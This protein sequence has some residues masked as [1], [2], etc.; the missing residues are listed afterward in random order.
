M[1]YD[2]LLLHAPAIYDFRERILF[3]GPI[4]ETVSGSSSQF[5]IFP[6][7]LLSLAEYVERKGYRVKIINLGELM[8]SDPSF[9]VEHFI[10]KT[11]AD[12]YGVDLH[13][14]VHSQGAMEIARIC[15]SHHP[16]ATVIF[17]GLTSTCFHTE[18]VEKYPFVDAVV[19]G[20]AEESVLQL[21]EENRKL[22][23]VPNVTYRDDNNKVCINPQIKPAA[24][25]DEFEFTRLDLVE[26]VDMLTWV[27]P[28]MRWWNLPICR[29]CTLDC[30]ACGGSKYSYD[31]LFSRR[32]P[33][34]RSPQRIAEDLI[35][36]SEQGVNAVFLFQDP[37]LGGSRYSEDLIATLHREKVDTAIYL[38][39]FYPASEDYLKSLSRLERPVALSISPE[40]AVEEI[41]ATHGRSYSNEAL[42][43]TMAT[44]QKYDLRLVIFFMLG[45]ANETYDTVKE[46]LDFCEK[47]YRMD[48]GPRYELSD[49]GM[50]T[51]HWLIPRIGPM[52]LLDP[53]SYGFSHPRE[54]GYRLIFKNFED[55]YNGMS[56]PSWHQWI[57]YETK[58][59][60]KSDLVEITLR[61]LESMI[62]LEQKYSVREDPVESRNRA[63]RLFR[64]RSNRFL[65]SEFERVSRLSDEAQRNVRI[66]EL[67]NALN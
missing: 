46:T 59:L 5:I 45:L 61:A 27:Q 18:I 67:W 31:K 40:S 47:V 34:F 4:D 3:T 29:G 7:G 11:E 52:I 28:G 60:S 37:R 13:W 19:R 65:A 49:R 2:I 1:K 43:K 6:V 32:T 24:S 17:G 53:C 20:E 42:L 35:L 15:K 62:L 21:L 48:R 12:V 23:R 63:F 14:C 41:R 8:L 16:S 30:I 9:N 38:E 36:L 57:S 25:L 55:Y 58:Y 26:P 33:A 10:K 64:I 56:S 54:S 66:K 39:L 22:S 50:E 44:C 51:S